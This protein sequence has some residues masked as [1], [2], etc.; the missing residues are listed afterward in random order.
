LEKEGAKDRLRAV[1]LTASAGAIRLPT[2]GYFNERRGLKLQRPFG[3]VV[4]GWC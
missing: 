1:L 4:I 3:E 2:H